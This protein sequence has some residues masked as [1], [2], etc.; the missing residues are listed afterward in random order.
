MNYLD[1]AKPNFTKWTNGLKYLGKQITNWANCYWH[2][3]Q[4]IT[5][6]TAELTL[7]VLEQAVHYLWY[8]I[9]VK[10]T[11]IQSDKKAAEEFQIIK[12]TI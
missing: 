1:L 6:R 8:K 4:P 5:E 12:K 9:K 3:H 11:L 7:V 2:K 10:D